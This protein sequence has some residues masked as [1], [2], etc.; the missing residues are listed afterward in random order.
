[1]LQIFRAYLEQVQLLAN[2]LSAFTVQIYFA[3]RI[4][5]LTSKHIGYN[6]SR[7]VK[8]GIGFYG[9]GGW[10]YSNNYDLQT[11]FVPEARGNQGITMIAHIVNGIQIIQAIATLQT[12][13]SIACD[14]AITVYLCVFLHRNKTGIPKTNTILN[15]LIINAVNRG[16]LTS[17]SAVAT[18]ILVG[19]LP[20]HIEHPLILYLNSMLATL[21]M[22][23]HVRGKGR[24]SID[25]RSTSI[26]IDT[27]PSS[28]SYHRS[29][30]PVK[31]AIASAQSCQAHIPGNNPN[32]IESE[33][34]LALHV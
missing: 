31:F 15:T 29:V 18:M 3:S 2:Y 27:I 12:A 23:Q 13:A 25:K 21:N 7:N 32:F 28:G 5:Q 4:C 6:S 20:S 30:S 11:S 34:S 1:M 33:Y 22:R 10:N 14:V 16:M 9:S 24:I 17:I 19:M 26:P 8:A